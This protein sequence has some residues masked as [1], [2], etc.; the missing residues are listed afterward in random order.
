MLESPIFFQ[1][2]ETYKTELSWPGYELLPPNIKNVELVSVLNRV[3]AL[4]YPKA[5]KLYR[6]E[7]LHPPGYTVK[8]TVFRTAKG[9]G[10]WHNFGNSYIVFS[11]YS[12]HYPGLNVE[13]GISL[14]TEVR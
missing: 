8:T 9:D 6:R 10:M 14:S 7:N 4:L 12:E 13:I 1:R 5:L 2:I 11:V 3:P